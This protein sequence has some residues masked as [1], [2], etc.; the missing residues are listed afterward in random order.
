MNEDNAG[1]HI[2]SSLDDVAWTLNLRGSDVECNPVFLAY[3]M[4]GSNE[5]ALY[6]DI[7]KL[8]DEAKN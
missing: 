3:L 4:I 7:E 2:V 5:A 1:F 6:V 8:T